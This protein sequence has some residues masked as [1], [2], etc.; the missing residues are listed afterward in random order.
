M[1]HAARL[2]PAA[3]LRRAGGS[4]VT[5]GL[6]AGL[7]MGLFALD[8]VLLLAFLGWP[9]L[10]T[11]I[12]GAV[13]AGGIAVLAARSVSATVRI[14][15]ATIMACTAIAALLLL[16]GGEG[17]LFYATADWQIRDAVLADMGRHAWPFDYM[18]DGRSKMLRAP[19]G[20]YLV[21]ALLGGASQTARDW[22]LF[23]HNLVLLTLILAIGSALFEGRRARWIA[24]TIFIAFSG[25]DIIGTIL[26]DHVTGKARWEHLESWA[27][28]YQYS[29]HITQIFWVPQHAMA[30]WTCA[31]AY[32]LW[33]RGL[34][35]VGLFAAT[36][37]LVALWSPL[38]ILGAVPFAIFAGLTVLAT[39]RWNGRDVVLGAVALAA[40]LPALAYL[41]A[42]AQKLGSGPQFPNIVLY[43]LMML[44]EVV[45]LVLPPFLGRDRHS[46]LPTLL[47]AAVC[48]FLMPLWKIGA[49]AD[50][51]MRGSIMPLA[52]VALAFADWA[53]RMRHSGAK[54]LLLLILS[55]GGVTGGAELWRAVRL[56]P[57]PPP[58]CS[59]AEAWTRQSGLIVPNDSYFAATGALPRW[60]RPA[61]PVER[62]EDAPAPRCWDRPWKLPRTLGA[63]AA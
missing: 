41:G 7:L 3:P 39:G 11:A 51:Q 13:M 14:G 4:A 6:A 37:P 1:M 8:S 45:P 54:L 55:L 29:A 10:V 59:L 34:A 58:R 62:V 17:R 27:G 49:S 40:T 9:P 26:L 47:I 60:L 20:M 22:A 44:L 57:S 48:L 50:F 25:W 15:P 43:T 46:D 19:L 38:A 16:L 63:R 35:P 36:V 5:L 52:L 18:L 28:A 21:P 23:G 31:L 30:G 12:L 33:R 24:A 56:Q 2:S 42:D 61:D 32:M 53:I